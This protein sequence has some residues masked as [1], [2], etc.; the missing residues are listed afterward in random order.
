MSFHRAWGSRSPPRGRDVERGMG[1]GFR[2]PGGRPRAGRGGRE[3]G[4]LVHGAAQTVEECGRGR[5]ALGEVAVGGVK[6]GGQRPRLEEAEERA[7]LV[8][9]HQR[10]PVA[11]AGGSQKDRLVR[12]S[13]GVD[14]VDQVLEKARVAALVDRAA[15]DQR[16]GR[17]DHLQGRAGGRIQVSGASAQGQRG[18]EIGKVIDRPG[19]IE[20]ACCR[21][22][23]RLDQGPCLGRTIQVS[24]QSDDGAGHRG[25]HL[26][27]FDRD[28]TCT[29][30]RPLAIP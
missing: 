7:Q 18:G 29:P 5:L 17:Q 23:D 19:R 6:A 2:R 27:S 28:L 1:E 26:D 24:G 30:N 13:R 10:V 16:V 8:F 4:Q 12:Q 9:D 15:H 3:G 14:Q 11:A 21:C 25:P 20:L 22:D